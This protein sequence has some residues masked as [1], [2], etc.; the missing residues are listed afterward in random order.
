MSNIVVVGIGEIGQDIV[1]NLV[2]FGVYDVYSVVSPKDE[3]VKGVNRVEVDISSLDGKFEHELYDEWFEFNDIDLPTEYDE[4]VIVVSGK[5]DISGA[6]LR[7]AKKLKRNLTI[8]YVKPDETFLSKAE[9]LQEKVTFAVLQEYARSAIFENLLL[10]DVKSIEL[11]MGNL[12]VKNYFNEI[13][14]T[15]SD[16]F[17][18]WMWCENNKPLLSVMP[19]STEHAR[20]GTLGTITQD[21]KEIIFFPLKSHEDGVPYPTD[22]RYYYMLGGKKLEEDVTLLAQIKDDIVSKS[23]QF[24]TVGYGIYEVEEELETTLI[25][26]KTAKIQKTGETE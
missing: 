11:F 26:T 5:S 18:S 19:S 15:I 21:G 2:D 17:H 25:H 8:I 3:K 1:K 22:V 16:Y 10:F 6:T 12:T 9:K 7:V 4:A 20:I 14:S 23:E 13:N 24:N